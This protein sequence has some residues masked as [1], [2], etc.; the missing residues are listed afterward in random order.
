VIGY[1][2]NMRFRLTVMLSAAAMA[3]VASCSSSPGVACASSA[4]AAV[5]GFTEATSAGDA[6]TADSLFSQD[7]FGW[8]S[9]TPGRLDPE[10]RNRD[11]LLAYLSERVMEGARYELVSFSFNGYREADDTG[12]FGFILRNEAGSRI[13]GKGA[14]ACETGKIIVW[15]M[16]SP[17]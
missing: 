15:S 7:R 17:E 2:C 14:V 1:L 5:V 11:T 8:F 16:G 12:N 9:E 6:S 3:L 10:A 4:E 13:F